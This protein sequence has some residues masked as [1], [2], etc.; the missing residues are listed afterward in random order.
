MHQLRVLVTE[1]APHVGDAAADELRRA[2]HDV[3]RC[4]EPGTPSFPCAGMRSPDGCPLRN[5]VVDVTL[6]MRHLAGAVPARSEDGALC[7]LRHHVPVVV[8]GNVMF[9]PFEDWEA[10]VVEPGDDVVDACERVARQPLPAHTRIALAATREVLQRHGRNDPAVDAV[11]G[12]GA[13]LVAVR[14]D[15]GW[16]HAEVRVAALPSDVRQMVAVRVVAALRAFDKDA[17]GVD[18]NFVETGE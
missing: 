1:D 14:R 3:V 18:V 5:G 8:A 9:D 4:T 15:Q 17:R 12:I 6:A 10:A 16:L 7:S 13:V 2:G 11:H